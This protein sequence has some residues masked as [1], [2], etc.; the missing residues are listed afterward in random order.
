MSFFSCVA[1][2]ELCDDQYASVK[3]ED[4]G[5]VRKAVA[6]AESE[7]NK[8]NAQTSWH[9]SSVQEYSIAADAITLKLVFCS[10]EQCQIQTARVTPTAVQFPKKKPTHKINL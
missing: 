7:F 4:E 1:S 5:A 2:S 3:K 8:G 9:V 10:G 6:S